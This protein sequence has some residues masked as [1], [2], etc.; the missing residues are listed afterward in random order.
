MRYLAGY[1]CGQVGLNL[2]PLPPF[3]DWE[4]GYWLHQ[5][6][7]P[8]ITRLSLNSFAILVC[9]LPERAEGLL[10]VSQTASANK[11]LRGTQEKQCS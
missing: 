11:L 10:H 5:F 1:H 9:I 7:S 6:A 3:R 8:V 4:A 2:D